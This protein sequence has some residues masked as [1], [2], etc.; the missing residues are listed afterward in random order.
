MGEVVAS[1]FQCKEGVWALG[2]RAYAPSR[3]WR[4]LRRTVYAFVHEDEHLSVVAMVGRALDLTF[5][6]EQIK[7]AFFRLDDD[8]AFA[9][10]SEANASSVYLTDAVASGRHHVRAGAI[11]SSSPSEKLLALAAN[12]RTRYD[13]ANE[14]ASHLGVPRHLVCAYCSYDMDDRR[15]DLPFVRASGETFIDEQPK[16]VVFRLKVYVDQ[17]LSNQTAAVSSALSAF[18]DM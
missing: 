4:A 1:S 3:L 15:I 6:R 16:K 12:W 2:E 10:L 9:F 11:E 8:Q 13:V 7:E 5:E 18:L 14:V 17:E